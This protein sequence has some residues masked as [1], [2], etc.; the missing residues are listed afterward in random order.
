MEH[1]LEIQHV[2]SR[3]VYWATTTE[4]EV[5][6]GEKTYFVRVAE[7]SKSSELLILNEKGYWEDL[8]EG[9]HGEEGDL[10]VEAIWDGEFD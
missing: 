10:I 4:H 3:E 8:E 9:S 5:K 6:I 7:N 1:Q 2:G